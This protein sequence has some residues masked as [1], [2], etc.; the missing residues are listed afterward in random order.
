LRCVPPRGTGRKHEKPRSGVNR[1]VGS[2]NQQKPRSGATI[3]P[4]ARL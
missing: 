1:I 4:I 2:K 3:S